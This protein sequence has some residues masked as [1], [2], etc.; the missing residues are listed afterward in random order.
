LDVRKYI[1]AQIS[2]RNNILARIDAAIHLDRWE[3]ESAAVPPSLRSQDPYT[4]LVRQADLVAVL[5]KNKVGKYTREEYETAQSLFL[6]VGRPQLCVLT[7]PPDQGLEEPSRQEFL[8]G[9]HADG[10]GYA[11][12]QEATCR[13]AAWITLS[14]EMD[15]LIFAAQGTEVPRPLILNT[16][17]YLALQAEIARLQARVAKY[18]DDVDLCAEL[19]AAIR[20]RENLEA[21]V[22]RAYAAI[23][24]PD[25]RK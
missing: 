14:G 4:E 19:D 12:V 23:S 25:A 15:R 9:L 20:Q 6:E 8:S 24:R 13:E 11:H 7:L 3:W 5:I 10:H 1:T 21:A 22:R 2:W 16:E 17:D 18:P